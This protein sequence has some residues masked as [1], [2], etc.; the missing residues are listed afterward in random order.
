MPLPKQ[1]NEEI[2]QQKMSLLEKSMELLLEV[3][4]ECD[5]EEVEEVDFN[6]HYNSLRNSLAY[7]QELLDWFRGE[8]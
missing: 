5:D 1:L 8:N 4:M 7:Q 3:A 2:F 6:Q